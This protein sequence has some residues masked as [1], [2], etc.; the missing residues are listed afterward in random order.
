[1]EGKL[2]MKKISNIKSAQ[3]SLLDPELKIKDLI[4]AMVEWVLE[5]E[6]Y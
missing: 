3:K 5:H 6:V 1:M 2:I 4:I